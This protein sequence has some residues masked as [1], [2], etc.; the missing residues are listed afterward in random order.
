[1]AAPV[2]YPL[3]IFYDGS[4]PMCTSE[5]QAL[6]DRDA[7]GRLLLVDCSAPDWDETVLYGTLVSRADLMRVIHARD[8]RGRWL[9]GMDVFEAAYGA[10]GMQAASTLWGSARLRPLLD[11]V[12]PWIARH[13]QALSRL[14][15][16]RLIRLLI[17]R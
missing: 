10:A 17:S 8:A 11:R 3:T 2:R 14:G 7:G 4:C 5:M 13:R 16:N 15:A 9:S 1:M 6:R 12:Y